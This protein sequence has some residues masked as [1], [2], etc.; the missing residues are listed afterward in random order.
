MNVKNLFKTG[1]L[2]LSMGLAVSC[3][4]DDMETGEPDGQTYKTEVYLTDAPIDNA[5]VEAAFITVTGVKVNG[6][7]IE[8]FEKTTVNV[9][10]LQNGDTFLLGDLELESGTTSQISLILDNDTDVN[11]VAPGNYILTN[12]GEK[13]ALVS[14]AGEIAVK[15]DVEIW[16]NNENQ[17]ILDFDL[18]KSIVSTGEGNYEFVS[19]TQLSNSIRAVNSLDAG[20]I[21]GTVSDF[22]TTQSESMLVFAYEKGTYTE[23]EAQANAEGVLFA[24]AVSSAKVQEA[25]GDFELH[26]IEEGDYELHFISYAD[27]NNGQLELQGEIEATSTTSIDLSDVS[28]EAGGNVELEII[29]IGL[30]GL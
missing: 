24:N 19:D 20:S 11:G 5:E 7:S 10:S 2:I 18:R 8:G 3:S 30:L 26:F 17:I 28:V 22:G 9:S 29:L 1:F 14:T 15:D 21:T 4:E 12:S 13:I 27:N 16:E 23:T 25:N 6:K